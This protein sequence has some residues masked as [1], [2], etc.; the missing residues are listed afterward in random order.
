MSVIIA[1][2]RFKLDYIQKHYPKMS[3]RAFDKR[4]KTIA[5]DSQRKHQLTDIFEKI[6]WHTLSSQVF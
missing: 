3:S 2:N 6:N 1:N 4:S 5:M